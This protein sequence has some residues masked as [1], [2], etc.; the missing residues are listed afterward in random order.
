MTK[1]AQPDRPAEEVRLTPLRTQPVREQVIAELTRLLE[2]G[3]F[4]PGERIPTE[5]ELSERLG[6]SRGT[7]REAVQF[8]QALGLVEIRHGSGTFRAMPPKEP[9]EQRGEWRRWTR[10]HAVR[11]RELLQ[12]REALESF[13]AELA[14][15]RAATGAEDA[16]RLAQTIE[17]M[18]AG[19]A[20]EDVSALVQADMDFHL[21]VC[22]A[23]GNAALAELGEL[24]GKELV[25]ERAA[26][27]TMPGRPPRSLR[28]HRKIYE[29]I[30]AGDGSRARKALLAHLR[31]VEHDL[32]RSVLP[33]ET[34]SDR[35]KGDE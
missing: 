3:A 6:V 26:T 14:A 11:V 31:S 18:E 34:T 2:E 32:M 33:H 5:R 28:E 10:R 20:T 7:V 22:E 35:K 27:W 9:G 25:R 13:A 4:Q 8:L 21:A 19:V 24:L 30:N 16:A 23:S 29:A 1:G 12:V 15:E 17:R